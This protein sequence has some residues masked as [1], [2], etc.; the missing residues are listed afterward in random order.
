M[1][2]WGRFFSALIFVSLAFACVSGQAKADAVT[3]TIS[4]T[5]SG[6]LGMTTFA[7]TEFTF[8]L[9]G[10]TTGVVVSPP[11]SISS[12]S[13]VDFT[14]TGVGSGHSDINDVLFIYQFAANNFV[15]GLSDEQLISGFAGQT[16]LNTAPTLTDTQGPISLDLLYSSPLST[17]LGDL[18]LSSTSSLIYSASVITTTP[19]PSTMAFL[20][21]LSTTCIGVICLRRWKR[22]MSDV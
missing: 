10:D 21:S 7:N 6:S 9:N 3:Y 19:E 2:Y 13:I 20:L 16:T 14:I 8:T 17:T 18:N 5:G 15:L 1:Q 4:G 11:V 22:P 12:S